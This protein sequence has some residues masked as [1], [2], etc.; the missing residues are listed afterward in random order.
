LRLY[1]HAIGD[2]NGGYILLHVADAHDGAINTYDIRVWEDDLWI[3][4]NVDSDILQIAAGS[5]L[6]VTAGNFLVSAGNA[7]VQGGGSFDVVGAAALTVG[8]ADVT[9]VTITTDNTGDGT[10]LVLPAQSVNGSE[11]LND[12]VTATQLS[13]TLTFADGDILDLSAVTMSGTNDEGLVLPTW[14]NTTPTTDQPYLTYDPAANALKVYEGGWISIEATGA[15]TA[16]EY[17]VISLDAT[18]SDERV[19]TAGTYMDI[20]DGGAGGNIT[21]NFDATE[22]DDVTWGN[23]TTGTWTFDAGGATNPTMAY[24]NA[25]ITLSHLTVTNGINVGT[26]QSILGTTAITIGDNTQTIA[27]NS[28]D[29]DID[30]TGIATG[31][32][33]ITS[34][35]T[36]EA[37]TLTEGGIAVHNNDEMDASSELLAIIDDE[38]GTGLIVFATAPTFTTSISFNAVTDTV[39]GIQNQNLVDKTAAEVISGTWE[40]QDGVSLNFGNDADTGIAYDE[41]T[42]DRLEITTTLNTATGDEEALAILYTVNKATSG[43]DTGLLIN[44]TDT[45]SPG[46]SYLIDAQVDGVS[47][48]SVR[49]D[50]AIITA[51]SNDPG[52]VLDESTALDTDYWVAVDADQEGDNDDTF[53]IGTGTTIGTNTIFELS[54]AGALILQSTITSD[55]LILEG[56]TFDTTIDPGTPTA[57]VTYTWP[58]A[59][60]TTG[61]VLATNSSGVLSWTTV[62]ATPA[63]A[64]YYIQWNNGTAM[65]AEAAFTWNDD[66]NTLGITQSGSNPAVQVGDASYVWGH[67]PQVGIEG[68]LEVD[69]NAFFDSATAASA[70]GTAAVVL[71][72]GLGIAGDIWLGDDIVLDSD[73]ALI[74][75]GADQDVT[76]THVADVG[77]KLAS[78]A[79]DITLE[80]ETAGD[81][82]GNLL[83]SSGTAGADIVATLQVD[84]DNGADRHCEPWH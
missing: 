55:S 10:D 69:S 21:L 47:I 81:G 26:S 56:G 80:D 37:A 74:D 36:V 38:T 12:T 32:G 46:T 42:D 2:S 76:I 7:T 13:A 5:G 78:V 39:A 33:N 77:I 82:T 54:T 15:P 24:A 51:A 83:F 25:M 23:N 40:I 61:Q 58:L 57:S 52:F 14:A 29:W 48:F 67:T 9:A 30:A 44:M 71:A 31:M 79:P 8:S 11:M 1:G 75:L 50:G 4:T 72:G 68:V 3:G 49:S 34:N 73:G 18:L 27:I 63:G 17:V 84:V 66:N 6:E 70:I 53:E 64:N 28:S 60:G 41:T 45:A 16:A 22:T 62:T 43:N 59:D 65:D 35:G 20:V 19:L